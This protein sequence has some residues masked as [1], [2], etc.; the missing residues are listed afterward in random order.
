MQK[1][2]GARGRVARK[3]GTGARR[4]GLW[5]PLL[6][7]AVLLIAAAPAQATFHL[8]KVRE[9]YPGGNDDSYVE[10]QMYAAGQSLLSG[11]SLKLYGAGGSLV[12]SSTFAGSV[13]NADNQQT[14]LIGDTRVQEAFGVAPDLTD[15]ELSL[16]AAGGAACWNAGGI[17]ADC[18]AWGNFSGGAAL[19]L[20]TGTAVGSPVAPAGIATGKA[21]RRTIEP[22]CPTLLEESDDSDDSATDFAEVT[23]APRDDA[24][25]I[26]EKTCAGAPNTAIDDRP[27]LRSNSKSAA[28]TYEAPTATSYEC[29]LD[30]AVFGPCPLGGPQEYTGLAEGSHTFQVRGVNAS[31]P[32]PTPAGYTWTVDTM[33]PL[34]TIDTHPPDPSPGASAQFTYHAPGEAGATFACSLDGAAPTACPATG[35]TYHGLADG[36][37]GFAVTATDAA[38]NPQV[39]PTSFEWT[40]DNSLEDTTPPETTIESKPPDPSGSPSASFAYASNEPGSSF[41]CELD[42]AAFATC[43]IA[44]IGYGGLADG[45]H[46]FQVRAID[47]S[48]NVD[49]TPAGYSFEVVLAAPVSAPP[50]VLAQ[51]I[52]A[53]TAPRAPST[54][55]GAKPPAR[56]HDRTPTFRFRSDAPR[57]SFQC[58]LDGAPYRPCRSP[59][60]T[61]RLAPGAHTFRVRALAAGMRDRTPALVPFR[62]L[63]G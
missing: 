4:A 25:P 29:K 15:A 24:S 23:P 36:T 57:A 63:A 38:G 26:V 19:E 11:H 5:L 22:G 60:T 10:L 50:P 39:S 1:R 2:M 16:S 49:P 28:F 20:A 42:G 58:K 27:P 51:P 43:P 7:V 34:A 41:E 12:H 31:G 52:L 6:T 3:A 48:G 55:I 33:A 8:I 59:F 45:S 61:A 53:V 21:I 47:P 56:T 9:V 54:L 37:H 30:A 46:T 14:V 35:I 17:P 32:D 40:V 62:V 44:G 13:A 18:V